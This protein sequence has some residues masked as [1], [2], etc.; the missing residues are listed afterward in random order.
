[1]DV[2]SI[3]SS[4]ARMRPIPAEECTDPTL[5]EAMGHFGRTL[6]FVP[7]SIL[8]MQRVPA[9]AAAV[10]Q[11][12]RAVFAPDGEVDLGLKRLVAHVAST[13]SGCQYC[14]AHTSV[15][16]T[17]HGVSDEKMAAIYEYATSPL[18]TPAERVALDFAMEAASVPNAVT[19]T[20]YAALA[21]H[22]S[23]NQIVELLGVVCMFGVFNRW[24]DSMATPLEE[25][26]LAHADA[27]L[28]DQGWVVGK[29]APST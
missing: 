21:E 10:I 7:N 25:L 23:E 22:W 11:L 8:T 20:S 17:R 3:I 27:L 12:N 14:K 4:V 19:D 26:P 13:A 16:A 18:F 2:A 15:S 9:I 28:G 6:G 24:N 29:H 5:I 1:V